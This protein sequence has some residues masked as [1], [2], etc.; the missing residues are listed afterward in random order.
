M[1]FYA[2]SKPKKLS[3]KEKEE[4][5]SNFQKLLSSLEDNL[6]KWEKDILKHAQDKVLNEIEESQKTL[7]DHLEETEQ[8]AKDFFRCYGKYF[9]ENEQEL[10][11]VAC[12]NHDLGK[13][14]IVFQ[15]MVQPKL[16]QLYKEIKT[17][18]IPHGY[19]SAVSISSDDFLQK[20]PTISEEDFYTM[21]TAINYHHTREDNYTDK[22]IRE[23]CE[24]YY[25]N[26]LKEF[27]QD[28]K[29][30]E[31]YFNRANLIFENKSW[32]VVDENQWAKYLLIKGMLNK[33]DWTVSAGYME[34]EINSDL[35]QKRLKSKIEEKWAPNFRPVQV[36]MKEHKDE[37][38]VVIAPTGSGKTEAALLWIDGEKGF[39]TLPLKVSSNAIYERIQNVYDYKHVLLLH[40]DSMMK[41]LEESSEDKEID[42]YTKYEKAKLL[43]APLTICTVDQLFKFVYKALGQ[44][45][46][47]LL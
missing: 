35:V 2:K 12:R 31:D 30:E 6:E 38:L 26:Y 33:F 7:K 39:Y 34:A 18:Q 17:K 47:Q 29:W 8:S 15:I 14:N 41:Y 22:D 32:N 5:Q 3:Q 45:Y 37:N 10:I 11:L 24:Q 9:T 21:I 4:I 13:A 28:D 23:Y 19:L 16:K 20:N 1:E 36:Y 44:K 40:S 42:G 43:S 46:L 25:N 27:L